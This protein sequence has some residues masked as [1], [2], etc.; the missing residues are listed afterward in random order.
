MSNTVSA[1]SLVGMRHLVLVFDPETNAWDVRRYSCDSFDD[2]VDI[3][4]RASEAA[5]RG[6][7][8]VIVAA[9]VRECGLFDAWS[10]MTE[11]LDAE[12]P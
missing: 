2:M 6:G 10:R 4:N 1:S 7:G 8:I 11:T 12:R 3:H 5:M 9:Q